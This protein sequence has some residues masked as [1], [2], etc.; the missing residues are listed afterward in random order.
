MHGDMG[1]D[2]FMS[3]S[4]QLFRISS[5]CSATVLEAAAVSAYGEVASSEPQRKVDPAGF[6]QLHGSQHC[7][8]PGAHTE[9]VDWLDLG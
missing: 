1:I 8:H 5:A 9:Y 2:M 3:I 4:Q 7:P 6:E